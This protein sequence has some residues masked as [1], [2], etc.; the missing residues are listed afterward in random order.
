M[1]SGGLRGVLWGTPTQRTIFI[2]VLCISRVSP[3]SILNRNGFTLNGDDNIEK[4]YNQNDVKGMES[5][6]HVNNHMEDKNL[7]NIKT[8]QEGVSD[9]PVKQPTLY[10]NFAKTADKSS[11]VLVPCCVSGPSK[12]SIKVV[13][14]S[15]KSDQL[16]KQRASNTK[17]TR[18]EINIFINA[19]TEEANNNVEI[20]EE[21]RNSPWLLTEE[22]DQVGQ[23]LSEKSLQ[24]VLETPQTM[25][26]KP[27][28]NTGRQARPGS[29]P[30]S[31]SRFNAIF[32]SVGEPAVLG[33]GLVGNA[34]LAVVFLIT[35]LRLRV[36][37]HTM[38]AASIC[39]L[40]YTAGCLLMHVASRGVRVLALPAACQLI[41]FTLIL[42]QIMS[43]WCLFFSHLC[44]Y[45]N[46]EEKICIHSSLY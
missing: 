27:R 14:R 11:D 20:H 39:D 7:D 4:S 13:A 5:Y 29:S 6:K 18:R 26:D 19:K 45:E 2:I 21:K 42:S 33:L 28:A 22:L 16:V 43:T 8:M 41:T 46:L 35:P 31:L 32:S 9:K 34:L 10:D 23:D 3:S 17:K 36:I 30:S 24:K 1:I 38:A 44:K 40:L 37:S 15:A 12:D 25:E